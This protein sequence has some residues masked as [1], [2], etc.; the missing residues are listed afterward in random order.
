MF[1]YGT[2]LQDLVFNILLQLQQHFVGNKIF[3]Q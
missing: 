2:A 3:A 1:I